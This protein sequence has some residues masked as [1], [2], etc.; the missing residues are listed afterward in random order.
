MVLKVILFLSTE[1]LQTHESV[2]N[3]P[4]RSPNPPVMNIYFFGHSLDKTDGDVLRK[5]ILQEY[6]TTTIFYHSREVLRKQIANLIAVI[7][8][9]EL[10][11]R[12]DKSTQTIFFESIENVT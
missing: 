7:G 10:I 9:D 11:K 2:I 12:T 5:M 1:W 8:E 4:R 6:N 3:S